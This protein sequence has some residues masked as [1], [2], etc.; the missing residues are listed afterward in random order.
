[1]NKG[2]VPIQGL[3]II[4]LLLVGGCTT[5]DQ[6]QTIEDNMSCR[7]ILS[8]IENSTKVS[9]KATTHAAAGLGGGVV[10]IALTVPAI[11]LPAM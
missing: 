6:V 7:V 11:G 10:A 9:K 2:I 5:T 4:V 1:M 3:I 8:E